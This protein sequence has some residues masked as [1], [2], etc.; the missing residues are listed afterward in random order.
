MLYLKLKGVRVSY[1]VKPLKRDQPLNKGQSAC[2]QWW[3]LF[4]GFTVVKDFI[5]VDRRKVH[6]TVS[7]LTSCITIG[8]TIGL[9]PNQKSCPHSAGRTYSQLT[10]TDSE[11]W[12]MDYVYGQV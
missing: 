12:K 5:E 9:P 2:P 1:K 11:V 4:G 6:A 7:Q 3:L 10:P 8:T